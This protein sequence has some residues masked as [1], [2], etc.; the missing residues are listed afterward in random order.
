[1]IINGNGDKVLVN[2]ASGKGGSQAM[3][4]RAVSVLQ[5]Q[6][7]INQPTIMH[8]DGD[9]VQQSTKDIALNII[10]NEALSETKKGER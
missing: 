8:H 10:G 3:W 7:I 6:T 2:P 5:V 1:M 9:T 4:R